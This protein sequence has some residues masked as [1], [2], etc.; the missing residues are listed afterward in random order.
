VDRVLSGYPQRKGI[1]DFVPVRK[2]GR[3]AL[4]EFEL[5]LGSSFDREMENL[6]KA[7]ESL[8]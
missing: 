5:Q 8:A 6:K 7:I 1:Y 4:E 2:T 3:H